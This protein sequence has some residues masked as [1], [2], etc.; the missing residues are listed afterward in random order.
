MIDFELTNDQKMILEAVEEFGRKEIT[1]R[2]KEMTEKKE[3]PEEIIKGMADLGLLGMCVSQ[4][5]GGM[6]LDA[7]LA[8]LVGEK[9]ARAD[10]TCS[11][12]VRFLVECSW[13]YLF[14]KYGTKEAKEEILPKVCQ[15]KRFLGIA[16]TEPDAGSD[17]AAMRMLIKKIS[18]NESAA[19]G[20]KLYISGIKEAKK[21]GGGYVTL[22]KQ[23]PEKGTRGMT[24]FYLPLAV[25]G[26]LFPGITTRLE[27]ER[28]REGISCGGFSLND[29][30]IP[31]KY[32][33]GE[34]EKGF[35]IVHCG[36][37]FAR[38]I[39]ALVCV[40]AAEKVLEEIEEHIKQKKVFSKSLASNEVIQQKLAEHHA[41]LEGQRI[42]ALKALWMY[43][44]EQKE[45]RFN[46]KE[47]STE[48]AMAKMFSPA[49]A[50]EAIDYA[51]QLQGAFGFT[52]ESD[53][54]G[55]WMSVRSF[56]WA[57][58]ANEI[59]KVIVAKNII[60]KEFFTR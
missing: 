34:E 35:Y 46:R 1:P 6:G 12:A 56:M 10:P 36:Y 57:E 21:G 26:V 16:T 42:L 19:N 17:L 53:F 14:D 13:S 27:E 51:A 43:E 23:T 45:N 37:E 58:G 30:K 20:E 59:M 9:L 38:G 60:G 24:L 25:P 55:I 48:I 33:I 18:N 8:G 50:L 29:V 49:Y 22:A 54:L 39:I 2:V 40:G 15:G 32:I 4:E 3:I 52:M 28:G 44:K 5:Y 47:V 11:V 41:K 31:A 7:V